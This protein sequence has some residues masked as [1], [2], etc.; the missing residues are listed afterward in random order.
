LGKVGNVYIVAIATA[1]NAHIKFSYWAESRFPL[2]AIMSIIGGSIGVLTLVVMF[3]LLYLIDCTIK[4]S[5]DDTVNHVKNEFTTVIEELEPGKTHNITENSSNYSM[6][7]N[8]S[9]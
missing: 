5:L 4:Q 9:P 6:T 8:A 2:W 1:N 7:L 3:I